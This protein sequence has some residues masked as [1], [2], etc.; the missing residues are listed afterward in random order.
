MGTRSLTVVTSSWNGDDKPR[1]C[2]TIYRHWD[3]Y[4]SGHGRWLA[5]F[6]KE[7]VVTNGKDDKPKH[8]N[9]P[10]RLA[11]GITAALQ[12]D[13]HDPDLMDKGVVMGQEYEYHIHCD[14]GTG[15]GELS[16]SVLDGPMTLFGGGGEDCTNKVFTGTVA[17]F[18]QFI[19]KEEARQ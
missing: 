9:G 2:A 5:D 16:V 19:V 17:E 15:G 14:Y 8:Y 10:G 6:L 11:A 1:H 18:E 7:A 3:G 12:A 4:P 13:G